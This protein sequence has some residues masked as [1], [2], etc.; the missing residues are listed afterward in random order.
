MGAIVSGGF[1]GKCNVFIRNKLQEK[2]WALGRSQRRQKKM[3]PFLSSI[4]EKQLE[5]WI[6]SY[7]QVIHNA[8]LPTVVIVQVVVAPACDKKE[9]L[10]LYKCL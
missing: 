7:Q 9:V 6:L 2:C 4:A 10:G 8:K 3:M 5:E 1:V